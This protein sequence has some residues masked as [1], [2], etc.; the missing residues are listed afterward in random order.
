MTSNIKRRLEQHNRGRNKSTKGYLPFE[1]LYEKEFRNRD[2]ARDFEKY[3]KVKSNKEK[4]ISLLK[5][6]DNVGV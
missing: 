4:L 1:L 5:G 2:E 3:L 6:K